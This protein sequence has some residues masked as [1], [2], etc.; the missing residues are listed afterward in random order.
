MAVEIIM[1]GR[2][3]FAPKPWGWENWILNDEGA[4]LCQKA[5]FIKAGH[6]GAI[7]RHLSS[8]AVLVCDS[9]C[10]VI[11]YLQGNPARAASAGLQAMIAVQTVQI[12]PGMAVQLPMGEWYRL[13]ASV[14]TYAYEASTFRQSGDTE[15]ADDWTDILDPEENS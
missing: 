8:D 10:L 13:A 5:L 6:G 12:T 4:N 15:Q 11:E 14:D 3:T 9:G 1:P 7:H 2:Q